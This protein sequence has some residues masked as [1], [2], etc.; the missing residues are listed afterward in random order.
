MQRD[1]GQG[2]CPAVALIVLSHANV[3]SPHAQTLPWL[4]FGLCCSGFLLPGGAPG[5]CPLPPCGLRA[6]GRP[7]PDRI[8]DLSTVNGRFDLTLIPAGALPPLLPCISH[9]FGKIRQA[10]PE[11]SWAVPESLP[12]Q[13][14]LQP[15][16]RGLYNRLTLSRLKSRWEHDA[17]V[18]YRVRHPLD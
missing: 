12:F 6:Q 13:E 16:T 5:E 15:R 14:P 4:P 18:L 1:G 17:R 2:R 10:A 8:A 3:A 9:A 11:K 7:S